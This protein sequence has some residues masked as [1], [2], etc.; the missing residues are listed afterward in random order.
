MVVNDWREP[1]TCIIKIMMAAEFDKSAI[2]CYQSPPRL[3]QNRAKMW[4]SPDISNN[5]HE[6]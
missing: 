3:T 1:E 2:K 5:A 6:L 4:S